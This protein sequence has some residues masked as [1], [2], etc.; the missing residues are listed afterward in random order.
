MP[1]YEKLRNMQ[2]RGFQNQVLGAVKQP[3]TGRLRSFFNSP[4][5]IW[6]L[7]A[8]L[9]TVGGGYITNHQQCMRDA[10][11]IIDRRSHLALEIFSRN[12]AFQTKVADAKTLQPPFFPGNQG[13]LYPDLSK[14]SYGEVERELWSLNE[15]IEME[16]LPDTKMQTAQVRWLDFNSSRVDREYE[17]FR[18]PLISTKPDEALKELKIT[19]EL[20]SLYDAFSRDLDMLAY[21]YQPDCTILKTL[22]TALGYKPQIVRAS[23]STFFSLGDTYVILKDDMD[24]IDKKQREIGRR[25]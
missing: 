14:I 18:Q 2:L 23:I 21:Y 7:S 4:F 20:Q 12:A 8:I 24:Q 17:K 13:S 11:H 15:R 19:V 22:G 10:D 3:K 1:R 9:L 6:C 25:P 16:E 5:V